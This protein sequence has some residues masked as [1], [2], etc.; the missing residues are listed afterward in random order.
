MS[1]RAGL[2]QRLGRGRRNNKR[3]VCCSFA[4]G[5]TPDGCGFGTFARAINA[6]RE[7]GYAQPPLWHRRR[8]RW[9][10]I[11]SMLA[12]QGR[13]FAAR[14]A[15]PAGFARSLPTLLNSLQALDLSQAVAMAADRSKVI[16]YTTDKGP[17]GWSA[18]VIKNSARKISCRF[19]RFRNS[20]IC[21]GAE[22]SATSQ[23]AHRF[24]PVRLPLFCPLARGL[25]CMA[26][27]SLDTNGG[28]F[29]ASTCPQLVH[30]TETSGLDETGGAA[31]G[32]L[33]LRHSRHG[34]R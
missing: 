32:A 21:S 19:A 12:I 24:Y 20:R 30:T 10:E 6:V 27:A 26:S 14:F 8:E 29:L 15:R 4:S 17:W 1:R 25:K 13:N 2:P 9:R 11:A 18:E 22:R 3:S 34:S 28:F 16:L 33:E 23:A 7:T 31:D 5:Q